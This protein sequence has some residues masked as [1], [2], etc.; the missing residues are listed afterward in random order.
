MYK[1][2]FIDAYGRE[3]HSAEQYYQAQ[4]CWHFE[5]IDRYMQVLKSETAEE[6]K[7]VGSFVRKFNLNEWLKCAESIMFEANCMKVGLPYDFSNY[8]PTVYFTVHS[9]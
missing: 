2:K 8:L 6:S 7:K 3:F 9:K 1:C 4:K 5:D